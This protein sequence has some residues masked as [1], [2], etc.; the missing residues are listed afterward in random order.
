MHLDVARPAR[1]G[2]LEPKATACPAPVAAVDVSTPTTVVGTGSP[3]SCTEVALAAAIAKGG[4]VTFSCGSA[5]AT[6]AISRELAVDT[7]VVLDGANLVTLDAGGRTRIFEVAIHTALTLQNLTFVNAKVAD[8]GAVIHAPYEG[9]KLTILHSTFRNNAT[10]S[11]GPDIGGAAMA[12]YE[13]DIV[14]ADSVFT[15]NRGS[16]GG[17]IRVISS[18]L[19]VVDSVFQSNVAFGTGGGAESGGRGGIGGAIYIDAVSDK[20]APVHTVC[21]TTLANNEA[22][23]QGAGMFTFLHDGQSSTVRDSSFSDNVLTG[24]NTLG[25]G[26]YHQGGPLALSGSTFSGNRSTLHAGGLFLGS[27][28]PA[29]ISNCTFTG[30]VAS[31]TDG[32]AGGIWSGGER[33]TI[34]SSTIANNSAHYGPGLF[35][36]DATTIASSILANNGGNQWG[37]KNCASTYQDGGGNLQWAGGADDDECVPGI[38]FADPKLLALADNGGPTETLALDEGSAAID[39]GGSSCPRPRPARPAAKRALRRRRVRALRDSVRA[40]AVYPPTPAR[41][42]ST[43]AA[44]RPLP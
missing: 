6:I 20:R 39:A 15:G 35:G 19:T 2:C 32:N 41:S 28:S 29:E 1:V 12:T 21:G 5:P 36:G 40:P 14:I 23:A 42:P 33:V 7:D 31:A 11:D 16:N 30:N 18:N 34:T 10:T 43:E 24:S 8:E 4:V 26:L 3:A 13:S 9:V 27:N 38:R 44:T 25:G 22:G 17:A 37:G